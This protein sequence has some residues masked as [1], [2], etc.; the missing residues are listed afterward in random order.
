[1]AA[2]ARVLE[3]ECVPSHI[4]LERTGVE[5]GGAVRWTIPSLRSP[6]QR[7]RRNLQCRLAVIALSNILAG[8]YQF[9]KDCDRNC[10]NFMD[11][12]DPAFK[13]LTGAL[14]VTY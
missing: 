7:R 3:F 9:A 2:V 12:K 11:R 14:E 13:E 4:V 10:P 8:L 5:S 6:V 1:M